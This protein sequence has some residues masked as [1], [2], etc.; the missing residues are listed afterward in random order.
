MFL[1]GPSNGQVGSLS[2]TNYLWEWGTRKIGRPEVVIYE[3]GTLFLFIFFN[4]FHAEPLTYRN[5]AIVLEMNQA[6]ATEYPD[7]TSTEGP[8]CTAAFQGAALLPMEQ[9]D[10]SFYLVLSNP[11]LLLEG[12][13]CAGGSAPALIAASCSIPDVL[14]SKNRDPMLGLFVACR[15]AC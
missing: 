12:A 11:A 7:L 14:S 2:S 6:F 15:S 9:P 8:T 1:C 4:L 13:A 5:Y 3:D 10:S